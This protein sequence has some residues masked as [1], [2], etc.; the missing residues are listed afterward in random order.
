MH[1]PFDEDKNRPDTNDPVEFTRWTASQKAKA[2]VECLEH[3]MKSPDLVI[4]ADT[5]VVFQGKILGKPKSPE[6]AKEMLKRLSG[7]THEVVTGVSLFYAEKYHYKE[8]R[9]SECTKV[10]MAKLCDKTIESYVASGEPL[11]KAGSYGIQGL[12]GT[13]IESIEGDYWN[14]VGFPL[15]HFAMET[16]N[17]LEE[18]GECDASSS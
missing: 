9:F 7:Q 4:G 5:I 6:D 18:M 10:K 2:V 3:D 1:S 11:D 12:G 15:N 16:I 8:K 13:L 17:I 14:V